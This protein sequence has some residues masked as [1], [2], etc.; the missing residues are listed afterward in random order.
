A[1]A[2]AQSVVHGDIK[3]E[4]IVL[5]PDGRIKLLDFGIARRLAEDTVTMT[6]S[7]QPPVRSDSQI[8]GTIAYMAPEQIRGEPT[9]GR[10]DLYALGI[11]LYE[12]AAGHR[13]FPGPTA[14]ALMAQ[15]LHEPPPP[16]SA[17]GVPAEFARIIHKLLEKQP[18]ARYQGA[19]D[20]QVDLNN[21][22]RDL[23]LGACVCAATTGKRAVAV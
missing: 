19:R 11:A 15:I 4:N 9:D 16:L 13:P 2:H 20:L 3:P 22:L 17:A 21:L 6:R 23:D 1:A 12:L 5:Q 14:T 7:G 18:G 10:A 8:A